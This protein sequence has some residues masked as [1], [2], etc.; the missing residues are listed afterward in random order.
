METHLVTRAEPRGQHLLVV[1][2][3]QDAAETLCMLLEARGF[4][5]DRA[6]NGEEALQLA[7]SSRHD[8]I[9]MDVEMPVLDGLTACRRL[10]DNEETRGIPI[11]LATAGALDLRTVHPA[12][13]FLVK[14]FQAE[15]LF[16]FM[17]HLLGDGKG[18]TGGDGSASS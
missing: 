9:I 11:L 15:I 7:D 8:L 2:D 13:A 14:P 6:G 12:D 17:N 4:A 10:K 5:V 18:R 1:D 3:D 16:S